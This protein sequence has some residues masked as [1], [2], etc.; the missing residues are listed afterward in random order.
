MTLRQG[1]NN[2]AIEE[3]TAATRVFSNFGGTSHSIAGRMRNYDRNGGQNY[4]KLI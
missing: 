2:E 3:S 4:H 1:V